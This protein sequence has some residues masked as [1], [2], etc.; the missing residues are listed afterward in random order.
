M[1]WCLQQPPHLANWLAELGAGRRGLQFGRQPSAALGVTHPAPHLPHP[2]LSPHG[3]GLKTAHLPF[4]KAT[5]PRLVMS[6]VTPNSQNA[7]G[8]H[9]L[10]M[11][12]RGLAEQLGVAS[13]GDRPLQ[14]SARAAFPVGPRGG[15]DPGALPEGQ[16]AASALPRSS[17]CAGRAGRARGGAGGGALRGRGRADAEPVRGT[18]AMDAARDYA[19]ALLR[20]VRREPGSG[21]RQRPTSPRAPHP[22]GPLVPSAPRVSLHLVHPASR[23]VPRP[24]ATHTPVPGHSASHLRPVS[25]HA[26][27]VLHPRGSG[28]SVSPSSRL[29]PGSPGTPCAPRPGAARGRVPAYAPSV[30]SVRTPSGSRGGQSPRP[31]R[32]S[33]RSSSW[34][35]GPGVALPRCAGIRGTGDSGEGG[36]G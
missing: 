24:R 16:A 8:K 22:P 3:L 27:S 21:P 33:F 19:G 35:Q 28:T 17:P 29:R 11:T 12:I 36:S 9:R 25:P 6:P 2:G 34:P 4:H 14:R 18:L 15:T 23:S 10:T 31:P 30:A 5:L 1:S 13:G 20:R 26:L 7:Q 32:G